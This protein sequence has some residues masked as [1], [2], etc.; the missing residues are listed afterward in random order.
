MA[1]YTHKEAQKMR[2][3]SKIKSIMENVGA[4]LVLGFGLV[5]AWW[6]IVIVW[7]TLG[8]WA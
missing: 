7:A 2:M 5:V 8:G 3:N 6:F 4:A 1:A